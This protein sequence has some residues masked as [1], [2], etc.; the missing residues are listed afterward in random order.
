MLKKTYAW[1][2]EGRT[3]ILPDAGGKLIAHEFDYKQDGGVV[4][5][6]N[7]VRITSFAAASGDDRVLLYPHAAHRLGQGHG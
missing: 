7:G 2:I 5:E 6:E 4:Y 1:D 3:G